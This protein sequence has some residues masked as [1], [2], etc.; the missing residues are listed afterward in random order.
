MVQLVLHTD[1]TE[2]HSRHFPFAHDQIIDFCRTTNRVEF[3]R[4]ARANAL[5]PGFDGPYGGLQ[6]RLELDKV[7]SVFC[8]VGGRE[9]IL[10]VQTA[11][12]PALF[13]FVVEGFSEEVQ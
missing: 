10:R 7:K 9:P 5:L 4:R 11:E 12:E 6:P 8:E 1:A 13:Q 3:Q 2:R